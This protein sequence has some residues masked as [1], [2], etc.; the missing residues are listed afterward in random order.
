M[1]HRHLN[2]Q[3]YTPAAID[4]IIQRGNLADWRDFHHAIQ[5]DSALFDIIKRV[6]NA[7]VSDPYAQRH[8]Y[9]MNYAK[10]YAP[11]A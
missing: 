9:W 6:C 4:D 3:R 2:H 5:Q 11:A 10:A 1:I 8:H 7:Y